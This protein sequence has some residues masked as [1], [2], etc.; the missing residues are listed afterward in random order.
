[1]EEPVGK[2]T[3]SRKSQTVLESV[4]SA[5]GEHRREIALLVALLSATFAMVALLGYEPGDPTWLHPGDAPLENPCGPLG[6]LIA[7]GLFQLLGYGAWV[8]FGAMVLSVLALAGRPGVRFGRLLTFGGLYLAVLG[9]TELVLGPG[10]AFPPGGWVGRTLAAGLIAVVGAVG[11]WLALLGS[12]GACATV[13]FDVRWGSVARR[14]VGWMERVLP[15]LGGHARTGLGLGAGAGVSVLKVMGRGASQIG[16]SGAGAAAG[17]F[18]R[19]G[20]SFRRRDD[21]DDGFEDEGD[22]TATSQLEELPPGD[23]ED[24]DYVPPSQVDATAVSGPAGVAEVQWVPTEQAEP[25]S[26]LLG[27]FPALTPRPTSTGP[28]TRGGAPDNDEPTRPSDPTRDSELLDDDDDDIDGNRT[29]AAAPRR[30][31]APRAEVMLEET[32]RPAPPRAVTRE[33]QRPVVGAAVHRAAFLDAKVRDDG[34]AIGGRTGPYELPKLSLLDPVPPQQ[35][36]FDPE[37]LREMAVQVEE[38]LASFKVAGEVTD[39]RV[40]PVV[41]TLEFLPEK[42]ISVRRVANLSDDLAMGLCATSVRIVAPIPGKGVVGIEI[43]SENRLTIYLREM[44]AADA[45]RNAKNMALPIVLGKDV[46]GAPIVTDL[47]KTPHLLVGGTTGSGKSVGVN[48]MLMSMLFRKTPEE[49]RLL[50]V[51]PKKLEFKPYEDIPHLLHPVVTEPKK[52]AA[53][54]AWACREMDERY[55]LLAR[56]DTRNIE[57][58]NKKVDHELQDWTEE[59]AR[60]YAPPSWPAYEPPPLPEKLPYIVIV[61]DELAD[62][63]LV[64]KKE[65]EG[66]IARLTQMARACGIHLIV[67]TQRPSVDVVTGLI[68]SNLP[69]RI[70]FKLR[71]GT[72]SRTILD[73]VGA[74]SLLGRGDS[75]YLPNAGETARVHGPF[76]SDDEVNRVMDHLRAQGRPKYISSITAESSEDGGG[77][78]DGDDELDP[79]YEQAVDVVREIGKASTSLV[80]RHL[81]IGYNRA[82]RIIEQMEARGVVGPA[83]G[84]RPRE[85]LPI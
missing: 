74:E 40:G 68:K 83:D 71:S 55:E 25:S 78:L 23:E 62:L 65:V 29:P 1:M 81:K 10:D 28:G 42:G 13:L 38:T 80:Q 49:L 59:K 41:T 15:W 47:A 24:D 58:Y 34:G 56:W 22:W 35:A 82:A 48:G 76:V 8:I 79:M 43:P 11:A 12:V 46:E 54:L 17:T 36:T 31:D 19:M 63:M 61:I 2:T 26:E 84:A 53:A 7:D 27:L 6:A 4:S 50:L 39:V 70:S 66:S 9:I 37:K 77:G 72:D 14:F 44:L 33:P 64:A 85:V 32:P 57:G 67:A 45:F 3:T 52:A 18:R 51:D 60:K 30:V 75:L 21:D 69:T 20:R 5:V 16:R 73:E